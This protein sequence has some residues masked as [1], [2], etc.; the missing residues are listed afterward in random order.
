[1]RE[2]PDGPGPGGLGVAPWVFPVDGGLG[3]TRATCFHEIALVP[4]DS[5]GEW[6]PDRGADLRFP[7]RA[8]ETGT[9]MNVAEI[10]AHKGTEVATIGPDG[11]IGDAIGVLAEYSIGAV[12]VSD[13]D[14][15]FIGMLSER[16]VVMRVADEGALDLNTPVSEVMTTTLSSCRRDDRTETLMQTMTERRIRHLPVLDDDDRLAGIVSI[17]DVV[18]ERVNQLETE[19]EQLV[20]YVRSGR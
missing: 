12:V 2:E 7:G 17:G 10:L 8:E 4:G 13:G 1:M 19:H 6:R 3:V 9:D 15:R 5:V 14:G 20:D 18:K 11:T 16:D